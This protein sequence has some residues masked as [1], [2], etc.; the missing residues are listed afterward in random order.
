[1]IRRQLCNIAGQRSEDKSSRQRCEDL[2]GRTRSVRVW[3]LPFELWKRRVM[4]SQAYYLSQAQYLFY[5]TRLDSV[6]QELNQ[7]VDSVFERRLRRY[8][9]Q[10]GN[11]GGAGQ[12]AS[13]DFNVNQE[14]REVNKDVEVQN[15]EKEIRG[16]RPD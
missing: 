11:S 4:D 9:T 13:G 16:I 5:P 2:S 6:I 10:Y 3:S 8:E 7:Q 15:G 1:M 14:G 12:V